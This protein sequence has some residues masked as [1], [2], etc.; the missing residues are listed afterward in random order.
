MEQA[1]GSWCHKRQTGADPGP[2]EEVVSAA[3]AARGKASAGRNQ[4]RNAQ[5]PASDAREWGPQS[6]EQPASDPKPSKMG[7]RVVGQV[8]PHCLASPLC[9]KSQVRPGVFLQIKIQ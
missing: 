6:L 9:R 1:W 5:G 4:S 8:K 2:L 3:L 7:A